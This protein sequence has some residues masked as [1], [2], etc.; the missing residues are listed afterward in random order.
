MASN[1]VVNWLQL[2][3]PS[4]SLPCCFL[5]SPPQILALPSATDVI[6]DS[7]IWDVWRPRQS[8]CAWLPLCRRLCSCSPEWARPATNCHLPV[9]SRQSH[10]SDHKPAE[11]RGAATASSRTCSSTAEHR[12]R[13]QKPNNVECWLL[14]PGEHS[15]L[16][17]QNGPRSVQQTG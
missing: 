9:N 13:G 17:L 6:A 12:D 8:P 14:A 2:F 1:K 5:H 15:D 4:C 3:S 11:D 10:W 7:L 16:N